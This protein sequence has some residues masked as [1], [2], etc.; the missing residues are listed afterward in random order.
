MP[1]KGGLKMSEEDGAEMA[2]YA[3]AYAM[4]MADTDWSTWS[5]EK[6]RSFLDDLLRRIEEG[7]PLLDLDEDDMRLTATVVFD[8]LTAREEAP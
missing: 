1:G 5:T 2:E 3:E 7:N 6:M 4:V 8:A